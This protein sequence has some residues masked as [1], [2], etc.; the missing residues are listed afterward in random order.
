M[1]A[2]IHAIFIMLF[3]LK[4]ENLCFIGN[5]FSSFAFK[6]NQQKK[7]AVQNKRRSRKIKITNNRPEKKFLNATI[8]NEYKEPLTF[9]G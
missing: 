9:Q 8:Y 4:L 6:L 7:T 5:I 2:M 3:R 1:V